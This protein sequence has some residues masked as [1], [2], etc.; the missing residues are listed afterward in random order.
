MRAETLL[1]LGKLDPGLAAPEAPLDLARV[2]QE[3]AL[4]EEVGYRTIL[5]E[6]TKDDPFQVLALAAQ[7]TQRV[8]IGTSVAIAFARSPFVVAQAA[9]TAQKISKGRFE[10]GLGSQVRGHIRRRFG[11]EW[12][13]PGPWM[14]D[15]VGA[16]KAIWQSW[17]NETP[18]DYASERYNL[19]L[20]VPLF[21][22][23]PID[24]PNIP[25]Q[26]AAV[27]PYMATVAAQVAEGV[28][29]H[30]V[31]SPTYI[32]ER[33]L[34]VI[35]P[36]RASNFEVCLK[37]L[38]ATAADEDTLQARIEIARQRL[39]FYCS[40]PA[41]AGAF[42]VFGLQD[43]CAEMAELSRKQAWQALAAK[44][45]DDLLHQCVIVARYDDLA[46][47]ITERY[48]D[49]IQRIEVSFPVE[50]AADKE[51]LAQVIHELNE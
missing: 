1:P 44:V 13:A 24:A 32:A 2:P 3:S 14:R 28:R 17:Q 6:E 18:L 50:S 19:N 42:E 10:L 8:H 31:C 23:A 5:M 46:A 47:T 49:L 4:A 25:I 22:P 16:V 35:E 34:P 27:N 30:P 36:H 41:Y 38:I 39:A 29:L 40:T 26:V 9:W 45:D 48:S 7:A 11:L 21:T 51:R 12:H 37:P 15:Y 43:L 33:I 20:N